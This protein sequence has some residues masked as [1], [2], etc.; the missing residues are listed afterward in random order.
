MKKP[1]D[2]KNGLMT[3]TKKVEFYKNQGGSFKIL[4]YD[5][6][7]DKITITTFH[8]KDGKL[9]NENGPAVTNTKG[10]QLFF[11]NDKLHRTTGPAYI[12][13][14]GKEYFYL[15]GNEVTKKEFEK[16]KNIHNFLKRIKK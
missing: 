3:K 11:Q 14:E 15:N 4:I 10:D 1:N 2:V 12:T 7:C 16:R 5:K 8:Y 13:H 9:H 6:E